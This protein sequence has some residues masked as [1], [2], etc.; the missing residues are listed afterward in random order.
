MFVNKQNFIAKLPLLPPL[1][2]HENSVIVGSKSSPGKVQ[3]FQG[4]GANV[5]RLR[6]VPVE[7]LSES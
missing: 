7:D 2:E 1:I 5:I 6:G 3:L 4:H